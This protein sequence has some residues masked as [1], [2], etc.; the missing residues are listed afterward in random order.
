[1][2]HARPHSKR[3][4]HIVHFEPVLHWSR[5][6]LARPAILAMSTMW[7]PRDENDDALC[8]PE[9]PATKGVHLYTTQPLE[10][11]W[12]QRVATASVRSIV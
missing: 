12:L 4:I 9:A 7:C 2:S 1:M 10:Q 8:S 6:T 11:R 5:A 3:N